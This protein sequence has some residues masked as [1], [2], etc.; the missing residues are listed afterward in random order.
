MKIVFAN[1]VVNF[2]ICKVFMEFLY[3]HLRILKTSVFNVCSMWLVFR[4]SHL[5][6][7]AILKCMIDMLEKI[8]YMSL[9]FDNIT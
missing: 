6:Y 7:V 4:V 8:G 3:T 9:I 5:Y 1:R 2:K